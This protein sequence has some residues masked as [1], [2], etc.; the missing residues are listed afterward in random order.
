MLN[1]PRF[2]GGWCSPAGPNGVAGRTISRLLDRCVTTLS[3]E[4]VGPCI[5]FRPDRRAKSVQRVDGWTLDGGRPGSLCV[6]VVG[7][8]GAVPVWQSCVARCSSITGMDREE[9]LDRIANRVGEAPLNLQGA[10][11]FRADLSDAIL[12][13]TNLT[14]ANLTSA[15]LTSANLT[16]AILTGANLAGEVDP[17]ARLAQVLAGYEPLRGEDLQAWVERWADQFDKDVRRGS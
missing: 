8:R 5:C 17:F 1:Q 14:N 3:V 6:S 13:N 11:L 12:T 15:N 16:D 4:V 2:E 10:N 7:I 9:A